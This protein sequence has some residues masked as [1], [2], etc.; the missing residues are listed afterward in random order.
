LLSFLVLGDLHYDPAHFADFDLATQQLR[1][2]EHDYIFQLGDVGGYHYPGSRESFLDAQK[3][4]ENFDQPVQTLMGNHD[5]EGEE[6]KSDEANLKAWMEVF[7]Q[8]SPWR[9]IEMGDCLGILL[10]TTNFRHQPICS[11]QVS[12]GRE[13]LEW[14]KTTLT[15]NK[16]RLTF[17]F[18]HVP[19]ISSGLTTLLTPH[20]AAPNAFLDQTEDPFKYDDLLKENPQV[21]LWFSGHNHLGHQ[22]RGSISQRHQCT[23]IHTGTMSSF[24]RDGLRQSRHLKVHSD[25]IEIRTVDHNQNNDYLDAE[26][27]LNNLEITHHQHLQPQSLG[28]HRFTPAF[29]QQKKSW[30]IDNSTFQ[31]H[32]DHLIE[33]DSSTSWPLG[34]VCRGEELP[35]RCDA[36]A[37]YVRTDTGERRFIKAPHQRFFR[38][39]MPSP[40]YIRSGSP[41]AIT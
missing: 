10:S 32:H 35:T 31:W 13:Q 24:S 41:L 39:H 29:D 25:K 9:C 26:L 11:Q 12:L 28:K 8:T 2:L 7:Q 27:N 34:V 1:R 23:F 36:K 5:L 6:F 38:P 21:R 3:I 30:S 17:I 19:I 14:L 22:Y 16:D 37:I 4:F 15:H 33:Y 18:C 40:A 20:L